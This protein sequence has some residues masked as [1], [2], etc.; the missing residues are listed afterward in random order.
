[1][2]ADKIV[3]DHGLETVPIFFIISSAAARHPSTYAG[4][5]IGLSLYGVTHR[6]SHHSIES[7]DFFWSFE[8]I[9]ILSSLS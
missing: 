6:T 1:L 5:M 4:A 8:G 7:G 2:L 9:E 3:F